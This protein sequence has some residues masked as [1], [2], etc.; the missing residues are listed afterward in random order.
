[1]FVLVHMQLQLGKYA[2]TKPVKRFKRKCYAIYI[3]VRRGVVGR[4][5]VGTA[6]LHLFHVLLKNE[7]GA[8]SKWLFFDAL[9]HLF[10]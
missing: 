5:R 4:E 10:S 9:T 2:D 7:Q 3:L 6:F 1:M 8:V